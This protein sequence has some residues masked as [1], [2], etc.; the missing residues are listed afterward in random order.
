[1]KIY[2]VRHGESAANLDKSLHGKMA[3]HAI[4]LS[5]HGHKQA[6]EAG[7]FLASVFDKEWGPLFVTNDTTDPRYKSVMGM[8]HVRV[9]LSPY[10]RT[11]QTADELFQ[12]VNEYQFKHHNL[13]VYMDRREDIRL[14]EQQFGL[15]DGIPDDERQLHYPAEAA[16]YKKCEDYEGLFWARMPLGES[17]FDVANRVHQAFGTFHRDNERHNISNIVVICH[18]V[19]LRA[20]VMQWLHLTPEWFNSEPNP[21]NCDIRL[22]DDGQDKGYIY[23]GL[24]RLDS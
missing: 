13:E 22:I 8:P 19:T 23:R 20:F 3:D 2:L 7:Q 16:H 6:F 14:C 24:A 21:G 4:P 11:R 5:E 15:F 10:E 18:G 9:W 1:M 12:G 17:R